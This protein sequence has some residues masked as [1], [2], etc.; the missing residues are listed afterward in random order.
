MT[1]EEFI[2]NVRNNAAI[3]SWSRDV[4]WKDVQEA[5]QDQAFW[6]LVGHER[7]LHLQGRCEMCLYN[8]MGKKEKKNPEL[9]ERQKAQ[10]RFG[11]CGWVAAS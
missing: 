9:L 8:T 10:G 1:K 3:G 7:H 2:A 4:P 6:N 11:T 5:V